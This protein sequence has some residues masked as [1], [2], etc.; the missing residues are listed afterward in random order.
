MGHS[1][2]VADKHYWRVTD[3]D[4]DLALRAAETLQQPTETDDSSG[5]RRNATIANSLDV[6]ISAAMG[7][8]GVLPVGLESS[9]EITGNSSGVP[10]SGAESG[11][12]RSQNGLIDADLAVVVDAWPTLPE[13]IKTGILA[14]VRAGHD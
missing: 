5:N 4:F 6:R 13:A 2:Q 11:A 14:M 12:V 8:S 1:T 7:V 3:A 9:H 10:R